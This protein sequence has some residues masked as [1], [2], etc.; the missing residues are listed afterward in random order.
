[1]EFLT[2]CATTMM[3]R[4]ELHTLSELNV[5]N[6]Y[7]GLDRS[8]W[9][10]EVEASRISRQSAHEGGNVSPTHRPPSTPRRYLW[11]S[12]LLV[13]ESPPSHS[14]LKIP[15]SPMVIVRPAV[16]K[17]TA[18]PRTPLSELQ[19]QTVFMACRSNFHSPYLS[20]TWPALQFTKIYRISKFWVPLWNKWGV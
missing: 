4:T 2:N 1:M 14:Q 12:F 5:S 19:T 15:M 6:P 13:A 7:I 8:V 10:Q 3:S 20:F 18:T 11:H 9:L 17:P 16:P